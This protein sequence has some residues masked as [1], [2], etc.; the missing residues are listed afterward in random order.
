MSNRL[1]KNKK[2]KASPFP[3]TYR[4]YDYGLNKMYSPDDLIALGVTLSPDGLPHYHALPID[5]IVLLWCSGQMDSDEKLIYEGDICRMEA[6]TEFGSSMVL[7]G[8]MRWSPEN[9]QFIL[10][11][12]A[13]EGGR[14][15]YVTRVKLLGNEFEHKDLV[16]LIT[17]PQTNG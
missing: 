5:S 7:Y 9:R 14:I 4:A 6:Q 11:T 17:P 13:E 15:F 2:M 12:P 16:P 3:R 10:Q 8:I 1:S